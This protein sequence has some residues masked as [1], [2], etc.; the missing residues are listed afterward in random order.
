[1]KIQLPLE[2]L[3][4][5]DKY[6]RDINFTVYVFIDTIHK[7]RRRWSLE[8]P[9]VRN[10]SESLALEYSLASPTLESFK[11]YIDTSFPDF[12]MVQKNVNTE[13]DR[14]VRIHSLALSCNMTNGVLHLD[15]HLARAWDE[16]RFRNNVIT[17]SQLLKTSD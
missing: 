7:A 14:D 12:G 15:F 2:L 4:E 11:L 8:W 13:M 6:E 1:M 5:G 3:A 10:A 17:V 9:S 16:S